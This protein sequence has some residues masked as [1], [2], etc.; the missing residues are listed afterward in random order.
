PDPS[1]SIREG[2]IAPWNTPAYRHELDELLAL[3]A[4]YG[5][6]V[7]VPFRELSPDH[8]RL[9]REGVPARSFGGLAGFFRWL[10]RRKYKMHLRVFASR[11]RSSRVCPTC[12]G[13][14]LNEESLAWCV[15]GRNIA[16]ACQLTI[17]EA[18]AFFL[19]LEI[20]QHEREVAKTML[21]QF[22][23][24]LSFLQEVGLGY[25]S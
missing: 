9:I 18:S 14:R 7:D 25:L 1:T 11:W 23:S 19:D 12:H 2:A 21:Q 13:T 4:D 10:E 16:E 3:A 24:R 6:P 5:I 8:V 20:T 17:D 15:G 22:G